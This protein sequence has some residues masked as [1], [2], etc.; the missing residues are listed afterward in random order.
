MAGRFV[1]G[2]YTSAYDLTAASG[3]DPFTLGSSGLI[4]V[5]TGVALTGAAGTNWTVV[6]E[7]RILAGQASGI[8]LQGSGTI[9]NAGGSIHGAADGVN[10]VG[11]L[12][13]V[14]NTGVISGGSYG[15][16]LGSGGTVMNGTTAD[17]G[18]VISAAGDGVAI[19]ASAAITNDATIVGG[20]HGVSFGSGRLVNGAAGDTAALITASGYGVYGG[21]NG[22]GTI[23]NYGSILGGNR[24]SV[25]LHFGTVVNGSTADTT[26]FIGNVVFGTGGTLV[27]DALVGTTTASVAV[28][29]AGRGIVVNGSS[30]DTVARIT[31]NQGVNL[32]LGASLANDGTIQGLGT[33]GGAGVF[34]ASSGLGVVNGSATDRSAVILGSAYGIQV[35][36]GTVYAGTPA[37]DTITNFGTIAGT[38][39]VVDLI[40]PTYLHPLI[41]TNAGTIASAL[42]TAGTAVELG[43][44]GGRV[45]VDPGAVFIGAVKGN[46]AGGSTLELAGGTSAGT[47]TGLGAQFIDFATVTVDAGATWTLAGTNTLA[48][49]ATLTGAGTLVNAGLLAGGAGAAAKRLDPGA[50]LND[51]T[52]A[53]GAGDPLTIASALT[54]EA[55][56]N[57]RILVV[58]SGT[59]DLAGAVA[60]DQTAI[61]TGTTAAGVLQLGSAA[62]FAGTIAGF[63]PGDTIDLLAISASAGSVIAGNTLAVTLAA[64]GTIDLALS[65]AQ[66][67]AGDRFHFAALAGGAGTAITDTSCYLAG[68][69]ILT[70][71]GERK[72]ETLKI[73]D[74]VVTLSGEAR[75]IL[76]IGTRSFAS[77][78]AVG[79]RDVIPV[80]I[81]AGA[82]ADAVPARDLYVSPRHAMFLDGVLVP[83]ELLVNDAT[84]R[85]SPEIDPIRYF[86]IELETHDI[87]MA[88]GA[89]AESFVDCDSRAMFHNLADF[90]A[91]YPKAPSARWAFCAPRVDAGPALDAIRA[92]IDRRAGLRPGGLPGALEGFL[93]AATP[94]RIA[95]WARDAAHPASPA[96]LE[97]FDNGGIITRIVANQF[98]EDLRAAGFGDGL[99]GFEL[100]LTAGLAPDRR[101][102]LRVR[103]AADGA[104][105]PGSPVVIE[106]TAAPDA[107]LAACRAI[108]AAVDRVNTETE[109]EALLT[110]MRAA[111]LRLRARRAEAAHLAPAM[112]PGA[113]LLAWSDPKRRRHALV[114]DSL[115]PRPERDAGSNAVLGHIDA[116]RA[117]GWT[118]EA[119]GADELSPSAEAVATLAAHGAVALGQPEA[120][121][122]EDALRA[123]PEGFDL[124]YL[125][126]L[127]NAEAYGWLARRFQ[128]RA[129]LI[130]SLAD[131]HHLRLERQARLAGDLGL[132]AEARVVK[133]REIAAMRAVDAVLTHSA[134][135]AALLAEA[136]PGARVHVVGWAE[137]PRPVAVPFP[138]RGG[139]GFIGGAS[140]APNADAVRWLREAIMPRVWER[141]PDLRCYIVGEGWDQA[142]GANADPRIQ[143][144]GPLRR[145]EGLFDMVRLTVAPL[146]FGAG[147]KGKVLAS[148]AAG[149]PC[150][151][152]PV[153]A[154]GLALAS[155]LR[156]VVAADAAGLAALILRLHGDPAAQAKPREAG[157]ALIRRHH[158]PEAVRR[159]LE[160]ALATQVSRARRRKMKAAPAIPTDL[161]PR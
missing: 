140:H 11:T 114:I 156:A 76:W 73:G 43:G 6:N 77:A 45:I 3:Q 113:A 19:A 28:L 154:E 5:A 23:V 124:I 102:E 46:V 7:G 2:T 32:S 85:R 64:G 128:P 92:G 117:L 152:T 68:T 62:A 54:A 133:A 21:S 89:A 78:S 148:L 158:A 69:R 53:A 135:E 13:V 14:T 120:S 160:A 1:N 136:A 52:I 119:I 72:V 93:D 55:G 141:Q 8:V 99:H 130:Y 146:R 35:V 137:T 95:G 121:S 138:A 115:L 83:A 44:L 34:L 96:V 131:L 15:V 22:G 108:D 57:G 134:A 90:A 58:D 139:I 126:R 71:R 161:H 27:N 59:V 101:H 155:A 56:Q 18:A 75:A 63:V 31:G 29:L 39:G 97:V 109:T 103:R 9:D 24:A 12:G 33:S 132:M 125:H 107:A 86:H 41:L 82:L 104:E 26:A 159:A 84:I 10:I 51:G 91:R 30:L 129:R 157:L 36:Y 79:N 40:N 105:L 111:M 144:L 150:V 50:L 66:S 122:V 149:I 25:E 94:R 98:R 145:L 4:T 80:R 118:V 74:R 127:A 106:A 151:L 65:A 47:L 123:R 70:D 16:L 116:L 81:A 60:A 17:T 143:V 153:A 87:L 100:R 67:F 38:I 147:I 37:P 110:T 61:F 20:S 142:A 49:G 112:R 48:A 88:E 42:G